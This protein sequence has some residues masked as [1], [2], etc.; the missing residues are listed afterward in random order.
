MRHGG[1]TNRLAEEF[2]NGARAAGHDVEIV[3]LAGKRIGFCT[4]CL[5][6]QKTRECVQ[7]DDANEIV[8]KMGTADVLV[9]A[10]P[11]YYYA[12][13]GQLKTLLDR[14]EPLFSGKY[15]FRNVYLLTAG[16]DADP[17]TN[18]N[19]V[20]CLEGWIACFEPARLA[21]IVFA[22]GVEQKADIEGRQ[23]LRQAYE[24]GKNI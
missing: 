21:G 23:A 1:N 6:C 7:R 19:A 12:I 24:M 22:G 10:S 13:S 15:S 16:A 2:A 14:S 3:S 17:D 9:F 11:I 18:A 4:G 20:S 8:R 5:V